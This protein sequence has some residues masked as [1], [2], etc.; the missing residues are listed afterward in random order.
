[1]RPT[2]GP[3]LVTVLVSGADGESALRMAVMRIQQLNPSRCTFLYTSRT[4]PGVDAGAHAAVVMRVRNA[5]VKVRYRRSDDAGGSAEEQQKNHR[6]RR[7]D[8]CY[9]EDRV[10]HQGINQFLTTT[11]EAH[12]WLDWMYSQENHSKPISSKTTGSTAMIT[13]CIIKLIGMR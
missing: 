7:G 2:P 5:G 4:V 8:R 6:T 11:P 3:R 10:S 13:S 1:M 9:Q 12:E